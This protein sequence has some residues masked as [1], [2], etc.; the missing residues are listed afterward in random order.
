MVSRLLLFQTEI[1]TLL[2]G[3][4][5]FAR[6]IWG[7]RID[8]STAYHPQTDGQSER[9][10]QTVVELLHASALDFGGSWDQHLPLVDCSY[11]NSYHISIQAAVQGTL[12]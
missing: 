5:R 9:T 11:N 2:P 6:S 10:I 7:T 1:A 12:W 3:I 8:L 4:G